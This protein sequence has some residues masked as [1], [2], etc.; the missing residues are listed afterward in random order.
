MSVVAVDFD[1]GIHIEG[2]V[3]I[4][5]DELF[6]LWFRPRLLATELIAGETSYAQ[7]IRLVLLI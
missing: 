4:I 3:E 6:D 5:S 7:T 1:L 2:R